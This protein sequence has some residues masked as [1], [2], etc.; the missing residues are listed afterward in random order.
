MKIKHIIILVIFILLPLNISLAGDP[1]IISEFIYEGNILGRIINIEGKVLN[2]FWI[3]S[4]GQKKGV[5][6]ACGDVDGD[7]KEEIV[8]SFKS[9]DSKIKI[10]TQEGKIKTKDI[11]VFDK[12]YKKGI[13]VALG[14]INN[15]Y[16]EDIIVGTKGGSGTIKA[17][18]YKGDYL[19]LSIHPFT[20]SY[21][22][23]INITTGDVNGDGFEEIIAATGEGVRSQIKIFSNK[24]ELQL[25]QYSPFAQDYLGGVNL[26][27]GDIEGDGIDEIITC[28][29]L[30]GSLC[31][32]YK[33]ENQKTILNEWSVFNNNR[34]VEVSFGDIDR[35]GE[36][37]IITSTKN[38]VNQQIKI[39]K[40]TKEKIKEFSTYNSNPNN[41]SFDLFFDTDKD[42][43]KVTY[44]D[45]G[46]TIYLDDGNEVRYIGVDTSEIGEEFYVEATNR[47]KELLYEK[48]VTLEYDRQKID[49]YGRLLAY[50]YSNGDFVNAKLLEEGLARVKTFPPNEKY[51]NLLKEKENIAREK[52][53]GIWENEKSEQRFGFWDLFD[54]FKILF[55]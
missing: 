33:Y 1:F 44:V 4:L 46:D 38:N 13:N 19:N 26:A 24:G 50:V 23:E 43:A 37:E 35:D 32:I 20:T 25:I 6:I 10:Y 41:I 15:D 29:A 18:N 51:L 14:D 3:S 52:G 27:S 48:E 55:N 54:F 16:K 47:N 40:G 36:G 28:Q 5:G 12:N 22:G 39:F 8:A 49:P 7:E 11:T 9:N 45:D 31:K 53:V 2:T 30:G 42:K 17:Y 34:G 21:K